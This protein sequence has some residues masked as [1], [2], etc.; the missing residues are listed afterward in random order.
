MTH[1]QIVSRNIVAARRFYGAAARSLGLS[2][3]DSAEGFVIGDHTKGAVLSVVGRDFATVDE[4][5]ETRPTMLA[6]E[7]PNGSIVRSFFREALRAGGQ[8]VRYPAPKHAFGT[9]APYSAQ[10]SDP[11]GNCIECTSPN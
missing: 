9:R 11:D 10:V 1:S 4:Q 7:A 5:P 8:D 6:F 3:Q 2:V